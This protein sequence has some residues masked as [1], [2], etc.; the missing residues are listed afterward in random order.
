MVALP[1]IG[2]PQIAPSPAP[3]VPVAGLSTVEEELVT[4]E[5][6]VWLPVRPA[7]AARL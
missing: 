3:P 7:R 2:S 5:R 4:V 6:L 1:P